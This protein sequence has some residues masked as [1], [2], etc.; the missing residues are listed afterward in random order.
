M[1]FAYFTQDILIFPA[2]ICVSTTHKSVASLLARIIIR[3]DT[4][5]DLPAIL[6][7]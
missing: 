6:T 1:E 4:H 5:N 3:H 2:F 7:I